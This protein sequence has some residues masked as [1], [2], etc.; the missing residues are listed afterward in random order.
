V[1]ED[2]WADVDRITGNTAPALQ[3]DRTRTARPSRPVRFLTPAECATADPRG[4]IVKGLLA[5]QD[6]ALIFG[7]PG[8]GKSCLAPRM[9][10]AIALGI[11]FFGRRVRQGRVIYVATEDPHGMRQRIRA[12]RDEMGET[13]DLLVSDGLSDFMMRDGPHWDALFERIAEFR[14]T[15]VFLDTVA[16]GFP[17]LR[18]NESGYDGM[19]AVVTFARDLIAIW[20][21]AV[22]L[23]HH[24][25]KKDGDT[26]RGHGIL[27]GDADVAFYL[28]RNGDKTIRAA[29]TKN[30][31]GPSDGVLTFSIRAAKIDTDSDGDPV[32][33]PIA[34]PAEGGRTA[35][36]RLPPQARSAKL[37]L[38]DLIASEGK[39][40]PGGGAFP[41]VALTGVS[42][43]RWRTE[44]KDRHL[45]G[46]DDLQSQKRAF[47][48]AFKKLQ[49]VGLVASRDDWVWLTRTGGDGL[50]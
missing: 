37:I 2:A 20:G 9:A 28:T 25:P 36:P 42:L 5:P 45:S 47:R 14:P 3:P 13:P 24:V 6:L 12:L 30:R 26:P 17:G 46:A 18:E 22:V 16:A 10:Y 40:L 41:S 8:L 23:L 27:H 50:T 21:V 15:V 44:C 11:E 19:G 34:E 35:G 7:G 33:A 39:E 31:N 1:G 49:D 32:T 29:M 48:A 4:Y 43:A 38:T